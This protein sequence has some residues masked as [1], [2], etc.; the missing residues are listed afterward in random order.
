[1]ITKAY[2]IL[3]RAPEGAVIW[4]ATSVS[5]S[6]LAEEALRSTWKLSIQHC[7]ENSCGNSQQIFSD[8]I[9]SPLF[10]SKMTLSVQSEYNN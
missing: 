6:L 3:K 10:F 5:I 8:F 7:F 1:M 9:F 2:C 4:K